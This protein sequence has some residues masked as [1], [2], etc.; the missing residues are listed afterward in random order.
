MGNLPAAQA[1]ENLLP[2]LRKEKLPK[3]PQNLLHTLRDELVPQPAE[4][5]LLGNRTGYSESNCETLGGWR[6]G[7][8]SDNSLFKPVLLPPRRTRKAVLLAV[9]LL[10]V[11]RL[12][13][14]PVAVVLVVLLLGLP[15]SFPSKTILQ[16][17]SGGPI[18]RFSTTQ[19]LS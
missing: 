2:K 11:A 16:N 17:N 5:G 3:L 18:L 7:Q 19:G 10:A 4:K 6:R 1:A 15:E 12:V 8:V 13:V 9:L 14:L